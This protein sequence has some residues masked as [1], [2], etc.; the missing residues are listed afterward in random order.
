MVQ[1][2]HTRYWTDCQIEIR[3]A[4]YDLVLADGAL[5]RS[6]PRYPN[7]LFANQQVYSELAPLAIKPRKKVLIIDMYEKED[8][9]F[10]LDRQLTKIGRIMRPETAAFFTQLSIEESTPYSCLTD[11]ERADIGRFWDKELN[12]FHIGQVAGLLSDFTSLATFRWGV[13]LN[14]AISTAYTWNRTKR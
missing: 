14:R 2:R 5:N 3:N 4:I 9:G 6:R 12:F 1:R 7:L 13:N 10:E 8:R 11:W